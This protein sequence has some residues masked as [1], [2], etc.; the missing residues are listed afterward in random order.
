MEAWR[1]AASVAAGALF[2][3][4]SSRWRLVRTA[5]MAACPLAVIAAAAALE[6][7]A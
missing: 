6:I 2:G 1:I 3:K 4:L 7:K 5:L